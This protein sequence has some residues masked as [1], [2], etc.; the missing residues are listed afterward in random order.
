MIKIEPSIIE[1]ENIT[2]LSNCFLFSVRRNLRRYY[3]KIGD[4]G[5]TTANQHHIIIFWFHFVAANLQWLT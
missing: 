2:A 5:P 4:N 1:S 3:L